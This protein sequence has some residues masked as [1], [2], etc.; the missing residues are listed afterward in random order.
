MSREI[1]SQFR[2]AAAGGDVG[3]MERLIAAGADVN[4]LVDGWTP[5]QKATENCQ[6]A[7][8]AALVKAGAHVDGADEDGWTSLMY[9]A[10]RGQVLV[11][12]AL[13]AGGADVHRVNN[14]GDTA[15]HWASTHGYFDVARILLEAGAKADVRN[16]DG[17]R[18]I[19]EVRDR[20]DHDRSLDVSTAP[21]C[22]VCA[23][24]AQICEWESDKYAALH[25]LLLAAEPWGRRRVAAMACYSGVWEE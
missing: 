8:I 6:V 12:D 5:L 11:I 18:P 23:P 20:R 22:D 17:K 13:I 2:R 25:A 3:E 4:A 10:W 1:D 15:L 7:A 16:N 24:G 14:H 21:L 9:A 19:D